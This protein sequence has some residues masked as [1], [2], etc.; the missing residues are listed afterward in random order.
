MYNLKGQD[1]KFKGSIYF[2]SESIIFQ[3]EP[4]LKNSLSIIST[5]SSQAQIFIIFGSKILYWSIYIE[6]KPLVYF[7]C[8][9]GRDQESN[10]L[11]IYFLSKEWETPRIVCTKTKFLTFIYKSTDKTV[12]DFRP[13]SGKKLLHKTLKTY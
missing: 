7:L 1:L 2:H 8:S 13:I 3:S 9:Q 5:I 12:I 11:L 6:C 10:S 4:K